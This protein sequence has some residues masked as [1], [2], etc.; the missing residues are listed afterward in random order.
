MLNM[1]FIKFTIIY[2]LRVFKYDKTDVI[3]EDDN[4]F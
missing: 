2:L 3:D 1:K 4:T